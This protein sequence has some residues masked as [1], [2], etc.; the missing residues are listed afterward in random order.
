MAGGRIIV[1]NGSGEVLILVGAA[2]ARSYPMTSKK[3]ESNEA[4][5]A[6]PWLP[7]AVGTPELWI[8]A[9]KRRPDPIATP[10]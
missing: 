9:A 6:S 1:S 3:A 8:H 4:N 2:T 5:D 10:A 7:Q